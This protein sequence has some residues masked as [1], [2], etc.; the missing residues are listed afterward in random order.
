MKTPVSNNFLNSLTTSPSR[1]FFYTAIYT[2]IESMGNT[3]CKTSGWVPFEN[4]YKFCSDNNTF[5]S[6]S[7]DFRN[8]QV[9][10]V[11]RDRLP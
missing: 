9:V 1:G 3:N 7:S 10:F 5:L 2:Y 11:E 8:K 4:A 6:K